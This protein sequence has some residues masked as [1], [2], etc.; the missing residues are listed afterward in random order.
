L[1]FVNL[2]ALSGRMPCFAV[3]LE[4]QAKTRQV[5][6]M[7]KQINTTGLCPSGEIARQ[8]QLTSH[9]DRLT[10]GLNK[11]VGNKV[12]P[13]RAHD[14]VQIRARRSRTGRRG[15]C[16]LLSHRTSGDRD[17]AEGRPMSVHASTLLKRAK[18]GFAGSDGATG[19]SQRP[20]QTSQSCF[21]ASIPNG[22]GEAPSGADCP[23]ASP[24][25]FSQAH[26]GQMQARSPLR[27]CT[28][29]TAPAVFLHRTA[30]AGSST[31]SPHSPLHHRIQTP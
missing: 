12:L 18:N 4:E 17:G 19:S 31:W 11:G 5:L 23:L 20:E 21:Q 26:C 7:S 30:E 8:C 9:S 2:L 3:Q 10:P 22:P 13:I 24:K 1:W 27:A 28:P 29:R 16:A 14:D 15:C 25:R 6:R